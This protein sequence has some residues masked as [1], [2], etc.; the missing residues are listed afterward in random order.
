MSNLKA[1]VGIGILSSFIASLAFFSGNFVVLD[2]FWAV[3]IGFKSPVA[4]PPLSLFF[5]VLLAFGVAWTTVD[6]S[7]PVLKIVPAIGI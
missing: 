2:S 5:A 6:I 3:A 7:R 4:A 1:S